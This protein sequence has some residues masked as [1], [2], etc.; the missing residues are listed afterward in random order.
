MGTVFFLD[1]GIICLEFIIMMD[2]WMFFLEK[3][4]LLG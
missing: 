4:K 2:G 1:G 3:M